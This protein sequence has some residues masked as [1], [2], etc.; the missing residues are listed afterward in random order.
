MV[1]HMIDRLLYCLIS[2]R[3]IRQ[4]DSDIYRFGLECMILKVVHYISYVLIGFLMHSLTGLLIS[5]CTL[6]PLRSRTGGY[7]AKSRIGCYFF[8]CFFVFLICLFNKSTIPGWIHF[9]GLFL[10]DIIIYFWTPVEN[11]NNPLD[12]TEKQIFHKQAVSF[13]CIANFFVLVMLWQNM[14]AGSYLLNGIVMEAVLLLLGKYKIWVTG[15]K[16]IKVH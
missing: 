9:S 11:E 12:S 13:L 8:S 1:N 5:T 6:A 2:E 15:L 16:R 3:S 14:K 7:H 4:E 10:A